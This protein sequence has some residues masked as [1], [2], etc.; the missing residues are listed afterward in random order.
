MAAIRR[1]FL[2]ALNEAR[3]ALVRLREAVVCPSLERGESAPFR[4]Y[5][6][7][8]AAAAPDGVGC[9]ACACTS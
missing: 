1:W 9:L 6:Q 4:W 5:V 3:A 2:C 7:Q 8:R